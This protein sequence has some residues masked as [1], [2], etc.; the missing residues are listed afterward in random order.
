MLI[1]LWEKINQLGDL[2][3]CSFI[4]HFKVIYCHYGQVY[5]EFVALILIT[6]GV[7]GKMK[8]PGL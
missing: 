5:C 2:S 4:F 6:F 8:F 3:L 7:T 1:S